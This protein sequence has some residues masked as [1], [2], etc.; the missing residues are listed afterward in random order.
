MTQKKTSPS[1]IC[2]AESEPL[3]LAL[4]AAGSKPSCSAKTTSSVGQSYENIGRASQS[5][6]MSKNLNLTATSTSC[7][8]ASPA[9]TSATP[10]QCGASEKDLTA[11]PADY[12]LKCAELLAK[13]DPDTS[14]WK[15]SQQSFIEGWATYS[16]TWPRSGMMRSGTAY[17]LPTLAE[18][19]S[20]TGFSL[21]P[22]P[23]ARDYKGARLL[24]SQAE[25]GRGEKNSLPDFFRSNGNWHYPPVA[26]VECMMGFPAGWL[27]CRRSETA[28]TSRSLS[29]SAKQSAERKHNDA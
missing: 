4:N 19:I 28:S 7:A 1:Q 29:K 11:R 27:S 16:A 13:Y 3:A 9:P 24:T 21:W 6:T 2:S 18:A 5:S 22:T 26:V 12:G 20:A 15:T 8:E 25:K 23:T 17:Q 14:S 10:E